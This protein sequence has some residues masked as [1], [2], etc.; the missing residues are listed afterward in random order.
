MNASMKT[1]TTISA[2]GHALVLAWCLVSFS[3]QAA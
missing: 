1:G 2:I 3:A